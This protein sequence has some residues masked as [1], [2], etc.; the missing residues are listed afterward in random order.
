MLSGYEVPIL[1][2][3]IQGAFLAW[4]VAQYVSLRAEKAN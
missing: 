1:T 2:L 4:G 3:L